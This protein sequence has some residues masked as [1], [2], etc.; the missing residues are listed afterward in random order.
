LAE[1]GLDRGQLRP[2]ALDNLRRILPSAEK[3]GDGEWFLLT[4][5]TNY[6]ASLLLFD[7]LWSELAA[8]VAGQLVVCVPSR[9][10]LLVTGDDSPAGIAAVRAQAMAVE[11][12]GSYAISQ[13]LLRR[14]D[15]RWIAFN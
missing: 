8:Y 10:V 4:A 6:T 7:E 13:T 5:G 14:Q 12:N 3:H 9:D 2:L 1:L 15:D 11:K